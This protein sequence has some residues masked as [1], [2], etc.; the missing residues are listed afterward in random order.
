VKVFDC[1][2]IPEE[3]CL[4]QHRLV[5]A[6]MVVKGLNKSTRKRGEKRRKVWRLK[7]PEIKREFQEKLSHRIGEI[8]GNWKRY[9]EITMEIAEK[10]YG[11]TTGHI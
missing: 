5:C 7:D 4:T 3:E 2:V 9:R 11:M 8:D 10:V 6:D 1:K